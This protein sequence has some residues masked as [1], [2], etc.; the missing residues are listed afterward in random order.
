MKKIVLIVS[1][2]LLFF[3]YTPI[4]ESPFVDL[5]H[6]FVD[7]PYEST[8]GQGCIGTP[9][10]C[11]DHSDYSSCH[12]SGCIWSG[13]VCSG[14]PD[15]CSDHTGP[16]NCQMAG[17]TWTGTPSVEHT[18][19][20]APFNCPDGYE[21]VDYNFYWLYARGKKVG[22]TC[23]G[24]LTTDPGS[25]NYQIRIVMDL[26]LLY[27]ETVT[28]KALFPGT[29]V[30]EVTP[31]SNIISMGSHLDFNLSHPGSAG[32]FEPSYVYGVTAVYLDC[33]I[34]WL[35]F[36]QSDQVDI[37]VPIEYRM[38]IVDLNRDD[39]NDVYDAIILSN[40]FGQS[41]GSP[42]DPVDP[43]DNTWRADINSDGSVN[44]ID[45]SILK[46]QFGTEYIASWSEE[47]G[48]LNIWEP[49]WENTLNC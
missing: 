43:N 30:I 29:Y 8:T 1:L 10:P 46:N 23:D 12:Y 36:S 5:P 35:T 34:M 15:P 11:S 3:F 16:S 42:G 33:G 45:Y 49:M 14:T 21:C 48:L 39:Q 38:Y 22:W 40:E 25:H 18:C 24:G 41:W 20:V 13:S 31:E 17:C 47:G 9:L 44:I 19:Y 27:T 32:L 28:S 37:G 7:P 26:Q 6:T 2:I 4:V